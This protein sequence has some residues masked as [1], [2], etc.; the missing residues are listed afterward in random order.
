MMTAEPNEK[1]VGSR[2]FGRGS[3]PN[4]KAV[5]LTDPRPR[6]SP[7]ASH[8]ILVGDHAGSHDTRCFIVSD[9]KQPMRFG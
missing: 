8:A 2:R 4:E 7:E 3:K 5:Q 6:R 9:E 1:Y